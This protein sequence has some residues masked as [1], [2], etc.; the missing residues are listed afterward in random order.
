MKLARRYAAFVALTLAFPLSHCGGDDGSPEGNDPAAAGASGDGGDATNG[1]ASS[2]AGATSQG[3]GD[4]GGATGN[5]G[6][7]SGAGSG[8]ETSAGA[9]SGGAAG[10]GTGG[11]GA[12]GDCSTTPDPANCC[13]PEDPPCE[14]DWELVCYN[15]WNTD[16]YCCDAIAGIRS[17]CSYDGDFYSGSDEVCLDECT[18]KSFGTGSCDACLTGRPACGPLGCGLETECE[19]AAAGYALE[20]N[21]GRSV[22]C[23]CDPDLN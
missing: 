22:I 10:T 14:E 12:G 13:D 20:C 23:T 18:G 7:S 9:T 21:N 16:H 11:D 19:D 2:A 8:G 5:G 3:G 1:G 4:D 17:R 15:D 6:A